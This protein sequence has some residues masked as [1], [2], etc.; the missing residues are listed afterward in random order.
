M[1][2]VDARADN[3]HEREA[4][5]TTPG[6]SGAASTWALVW[7]LV[8]MGF[9]HKARLAAAMAV[10][11]GM[12]IM[13]VGELFSS[14]LAIDVLRHH[15][16]P[17]VDPP[18][19]PL[20]IDPP[21]D[22][23][24]MT[25]LF[26]VA[27][28]ALGFAVLRAVGYFLGRWTD[29][30]LAQAIIVRLRDDVYAKLQ[31]LSFSFY[32]TH[33]SGTIINRVTGDVQSI[34]TFVQGVLMRA[35]TA[36]ITF[37]IFVV[38]MVSLHA[39]LTFVMLS[40]VVFQMLIMFRYTK[41]V[42]PHFRIQREVLDDLIKTLSEEVQGIR[43]VRAFGKEQHS[44]ARFTKQSEYARDQRYD[45][46]RMMGNHLPLIMGSGWMQIAVLIGFGG[47]LVLQGPLAG[48]IALGTIWIFFNLLQSIAAQIDQIIRVAGQAPDALTGAER[49]F[50]I[51]D[52]ES[53]IRQ[54][55]QPAVAAQRES[56]EAALGSAPAS[57]GDVPAA[58][59][60]EFRN[61]SFA[62]EN[63]TP[64]LRGVSFA[65]RRGET[66]ALVGPTGSGKTTLL[67]LIPRYYDVT[68]GRVLVD[69]VDVRERDLAALRKSIGMVFQ[70]AF[71]FSNTIAN[72]IAFGSPHVANEEI[73]HVA[74][75][76][77]ADGFIDQLGKRYDTIVGERGV[78]LSG[79]ERQ[80]LSIARALL[81]RP[82]IL[83][84]DDA[85]SAVDAETEMRIEHALAQQHA[86]QT[87]LIVAHRLSTLRRA[88]RVIVLERGEI[89]AS[90][91]HDDLMAHDSHYRHAAV[92]QLEHEEED[93][94]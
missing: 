35:V 36:L 3:G 65:I 13:V 50:A 42:R 40:F 22:T 66:V 61:V 18:Q 17:S 30:L 59:A 25:L 43:V 10:T 55:R 87:R 28:A 7:R 62:Y 15:V 4:M 16:D 79:G 84:L 11:I 51:L 93:S 49:V 14:G 89:V 46:W 69:S 83:L 88:D 47:W 52:R 37:I 74:S 80:R 32:D 82:P 19:W 54:P 1:A 44:T 94:A 31:S 70:E 12:Q 64:V 86:G 56:G 5:S 92:I 27:G 41:H 76:A 45:I 34:R 29:E 33:D 2:K 8:A 78:T 57:T 77:A 39:P 48:G 6:G 72:N 75:I 90:G 68:A 20:G 38:T 21:A 63:E 60:I 67:Q 23:P 81:I 58:H 26:W 53:D 91:T 73:A 85:M 9:R 24:L 71:L